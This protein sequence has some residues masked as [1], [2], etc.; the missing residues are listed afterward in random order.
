MICTL[1][2]AIITRSVRAIYVSR[3][4]PDSRAKSAEEIR[5]RTLTKGAWPK[6]LIYPEGTTTNRGVLLK[7]K[8]GAFYPKLPVQPVIIKYNNQVV[9]VFYKTLPVLY[10]TICTIRVHFVCANAVLLI[11]C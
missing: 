10:H 1:H 11:Y 4:D 2:A 3:E 8:P 7:F 9:R 5:R 6:V